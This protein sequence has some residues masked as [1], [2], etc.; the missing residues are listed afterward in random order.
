MGV[1][2]HT[3]SVPRICPA[4]DISVEDYEDAVPDATFAKIVAVLRI[5]VPYAGMIVSTR[6]SQRV[7]EKLLALGISQIS[8]GSKTSVG[9]YDKP[10]PQDENSAQFDISD[11]RTL[12]DRGLAFRSGYIPSFA[13]PVNV[14]AYE[15]ALLLAKSGHIAN[16][17]HPNARMTLKEYLEDYSSPHT[18]QQGE[19]VISEQIGLIPN[20]KVRT[21]AI[22]H[23]TEMNQG[24]RDFRF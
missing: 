8:G 4:D 24:R 13:P 18:R 17:C 11:H 23:L 22:H 20:E 6:E 21:L 5:A 2:P 14:G 19:R 1:G 9:G 3:I 10:E 15:T 7:R 16:C 12:M